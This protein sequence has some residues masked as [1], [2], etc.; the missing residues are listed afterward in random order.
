MFLF[1]FNFR[2]FE[3]KFRFDYLQKL[4]KMRGG[5]HAEESAHFYISNGRVRFEE[6]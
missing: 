1:Y 3:L 2:Q 5:M 4:Q 6:F